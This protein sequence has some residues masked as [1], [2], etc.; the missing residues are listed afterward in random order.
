MQIEILPADPYEPYRSAGHVMLT[1]GEL[2]FPL[3]LGHAEVRRLARDWNTFTSD[4]PFEV[5]IP[6][7]HEMRPVRQLP[8]E[9]DPPQHTALRALTDEALSREGVERHAAIVAEVSGAA[10]DQAMATGRLDVEADLALPT[11]NRTLAA[12]LGRPA[13]D[14]DLWRSWGTH[15]FAADGGEKHGNS[16][17]DDYLERVVDSTG[18]ADAGFFGMLARSTID[19]RLLTR[20]ERIGFGNLVFAG[21][22]DTV[23]S[24]LVTMFVVLARAPDAP[25][26]LAAD[27]SRHRAAVEEIIR[28]A[29]PL[30][31]I[32]RHATAAASAGGCPVTPG[33]LVALGFGAANRD[34]EVF[35]RSGV[36]DLA[37]WPNR[38]VAF[39]HGPHTCSGSHLARMEVRAVL[40][41]LVARVGRVELLEPPLHAT[42]DI[43]GTQEICGFRD[44]AVRLHPK[45]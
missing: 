38:H 31:Y 17:L 37:R 6:H 11:V 3:V 42:V 12:V 41:Q 29:S 10:I 15:V 33:A 36:C 16:Q 9:T 7:E 19:G 18:P 1:V 35:E 39:G 20:D 45:G 40:E 28:V 21:G 32:G 25:A 26:W 13:S 2:T 4:T 14:A 34:P 5:P 22:R 8:I 44:V 43:N 27:P 30:Q 24:T 23:V